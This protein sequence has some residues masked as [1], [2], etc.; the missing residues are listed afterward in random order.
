MAQKIALFEKD[1][2]SVLKKSLSDE[3]KSKSLHRQP[4]DA[5][6]SFLSTQLKSQGQP[7]VSDEEKTA[8]SISS[9]SESD[10]DEAPPISD[11]KLTISCRKVIETP[12]DIVVTKEPA[13][14]KDIEAIAV[15]AEAKN[16]S[17][18]VE[19]VIQSAHLV[20]NGSDDIFDQ[21]QDDI[22]LL[23]EQLAEDAVKSPTV[24]IP[25][26][27]KKLPVK[28]LVKKEVKI[29]DKREA[30]EEQKEQKKI[31]EP[32]PV[33]KTPELNIQSQ[34]VAQ[35]EVKEPKVSQ[36]ED[37][38]PEEIQP[39]VAVESQIELKEPEIEMQIPDEP[40]KLEEPLEP[41]EALESKPIEKSD[42]NPF[43]DEEESEE[44]PKISNPVPPKRPS[45]NP[46]GSGSEDEE[47]Q[48]AS[49]SSGTLP[50]PPRPPP[51]KTAFTPASSAST[52]PFGSDDEDDEPPKP[53]LI[54]TPV[55]TPRKPL[56]WVVFYVAKYWFSIF[57]H[58]LVIVQSQS[59]LYSNL[60]PTV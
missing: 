46:F 1:S 45:L 29:E 11:E 51:P 21:S 18:D 34:E 19:K 44:T 56:L 3:E 8:E 53:T 7:E 43:G 60:T 17:H 22:D 20:V 5:L 35:A 12:I 26:A 57:L 10:D 13:R 42:S 33:I 49:S 55:P 52:N 36:S 38:T 28:E 31:E 16:E 14:A 40:P 9:D 47:N 37:K 59:Q 2:S 15:A 32:V 30:V 39:P 4:S 25:V 24:N 27:A 58:N 6:N 48:N 50:K 54:R 23:F 41:L